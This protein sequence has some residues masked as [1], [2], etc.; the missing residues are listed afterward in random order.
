MFSMDE[1]KLEMRQNNLYKFTQLVDIIL[2]NTIQLHFTFV[3]VAL[4]NV[5]FCFKLKRL[6]L[7]VVF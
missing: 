5:E 4:D 1:L 2:A 6:K 3:V 7:G